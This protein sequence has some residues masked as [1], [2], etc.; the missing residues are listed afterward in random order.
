ML[1]ER[2]EPSG[3]LERARLTVE[4]GIPLPGR[5]PEACLPIIKA[6]DGRPLRK[7]IESVARKRGITGDALATECLPTLGELLAHGLL[8]VRPD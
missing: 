6:L 3:A 2:R 8:V 1:V 7:V 4:E 5:I